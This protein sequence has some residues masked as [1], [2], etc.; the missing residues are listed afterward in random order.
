VAENL[1]PGKEYTAIRSCWALSSP[2]TIIDPGIVKL[3][4]AK[5]V[6]LA[7]NLRIIVEMVLISLVKL[8]V[9]GGRKRK[10]RAG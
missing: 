1:A 3:K 2:G 10:N 9:R 5:N 4:L 6:P 8:R 7:I